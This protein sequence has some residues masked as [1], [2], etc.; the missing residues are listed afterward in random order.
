MS[1]TRH[2]LRVLRERWRLP[3]DREDPASL[4]PQI[5]E[6]LAPLVD[7]FC[8]AW[9]RLEVRGQ[10]RVPNGPALLVGNHN[11][12]TTFL[13]A[14]GVGARWYRQR[15][16]D[17]PW[18]G[19][20]HDSV[21][22]MPVVGRLLCKVGAVRAGHETASRAFGEGR[23]V[24]VFPGGNRE[25]FRSWTKRHRVDF[26][27]RKG[28]IKLALRHQVPIVPMVF[29]GGQDGFVVLSEGKRLARLIRADKII[30]SE[31]WPVTLQLPF[32]LVVGP[33]PHL[34]LPVKCVTEFLEPVPVDVY[35]LEAEHDPEV[36]EHLYAQVVDRMQTALDRLAVER[37][38][39]GVFQ[40]LFPR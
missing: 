1:R 4:D 5:V 22:D 24:V 31:A 12:G 7:D 39:R 11:S 28:F 17:E 21:V 9:F 8:S 35:G 26:F 6:A 18:H 34:P 36:L 38:E 16:L 33:A 29:I 19:L 25:A 15:G 3:V 14:L 13:E 37:R 27:G 23:K 20:A 30:R 2:A 32:G 40:G 10:D